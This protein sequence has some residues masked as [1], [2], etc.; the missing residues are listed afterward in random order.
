MSV[1]VIFSCSKELFIFREILG[2][3]LFLLVLISSFNPWCSNG[4]R[5][6]FP[7]SVETCFCDILSQYVVDLDKFYTC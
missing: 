6:I 5:E 4:C 2:F 3:L 7:F 1:L